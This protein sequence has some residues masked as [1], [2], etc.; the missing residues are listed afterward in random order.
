[1]LVKV[2]DVTG[3]AASADQLLDTAEECCR[4]QHTDPVKTN[5][6]PHFFTIHQQHQE[7]RIKKHCGEVT[8]LCYSKDNFVSWYC[9][10]SQGPLMH[11]CIKMEE[12]PFIY[13]IQKNQKKKSP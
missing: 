5:L 13:N 7:K 6:S 1:V 4:S 11:N 9:M 10:P 3:G 2:T 8:Q 12:R